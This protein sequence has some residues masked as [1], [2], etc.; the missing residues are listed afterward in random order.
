MSSRYEYLIANRSREEV[1]DFYKR[2][3]IQ[4]RNSVLSMNGGG[5][6]RNHI[7]AYLECKQILKELNDG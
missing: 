5:F 6:R 1:I 7:L 3:L 4:Y 2:A